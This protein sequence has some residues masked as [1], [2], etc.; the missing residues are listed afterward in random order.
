[1][2]GTNRK[3]TII[4]NIVLLLFILVL[5]AVLAAATI[6][7]RR[8]SEEHDAQL[9]EVQ[10][11]QQQ[12]QAAEKQEYLAAIQAEYENDLAC[13]KQY[14]PGIVC[15][16]DSITLG[17]SASVAYPSVL[18]KYIDTYICDIYDF[19]STIEN[20]DDYAR[21]KWDDYKVSIPVVNMGAGPET[22][23]TVL[24]R[25]GVE[26]F[27]TTTA[28][29]VPA[30]T[31]PAVITMSTPD[32]RTVN[33]LTGSSAG[34][35]NVT[36]DGIEGVLSI[37]MVSAQWYS[38]RN[39]YYF[40]RTTPG[41][42][43]E[44]PAGTPIITAGTEQYKDYIH[45]ICVGTYGGYDTPDSLVNQVKKLV[46]RQTNNSDRYIILGLPASANSNY[47]AFL[48]AIDTAMLQTFGKRYISLRKYLC[49]DG[50]TDANISKSKE[51]LV[52]LEHNNVP[53]SFL[54]SPGS[55]ELNGKANTLI[56]KLVFNQMEEL[57]Y[58]DEIYEELNITETVKSILKDDPNYFQNI[59]NYLIK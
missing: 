14:V 36:I 35:N 42:A 30:G 59:L 50:I 9:L 47:R 25:C 19:R 7:L 23:G 57:G 43:V 11:Q 32:G 13:V 54:V 20:A 52:A 2:W 34:I 58:F 53:P 26:P 8:S 15:W 45:V 10:V 17:A 1:M 44:I 24:G 29:K 27:V 6:Y 55:V 56:G 39:T 28:L 16:G 12:E 21:L 3:K 18:Q 5:L 37:D 22:S 31:E 41:E 40:T 38:A 49:G 51:D 48:D 46:A 4:K 33:P